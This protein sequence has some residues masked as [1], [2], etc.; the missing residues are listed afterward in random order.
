MADNDLG[1]ICAHMHMILFRFQTSFRTLTLELDCPGLN[2]GCFISC[3]K[4]KMNYLT[5]LSS[6]FLLCERRIIIIKRTF[7]SFF[8]KLNNLIHVIHLV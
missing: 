2:P 7:E 4:P 1:S 6:T 8:F 3:P 5:F